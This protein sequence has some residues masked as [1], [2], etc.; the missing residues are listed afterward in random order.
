MLD[1]YAVENACA[2]AWPPLV[3]ARTGDWRLRAA[4]GFTGRANS[5]LVTGSS[6]GGVACALERVRSF[7]ECHG[8]APKLQVVAGDPVEAELRSND[9]VIDDAHCGV[10]GVAVLLGA[11][12]PTARRPALGQVHAT[13]TQGWWSLAAGS[14]APDEA[15]SHVLGTSTGGALGFGVHA[16]G[17]VTTGAVRL[18]VAG[19]LL[20]VSRL[21]VAESARRHGIA[22]GLLA[23][24]ARWGL[25]NGA[26]EA[27]LQVAADNAG[28]LRLYE[29][30]GFAEHHRYRYWSPVAA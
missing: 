5:A 21:E 14:S 24:A 3:E 9:W 10:D 11:L 26:R 22:S 29:R 4:R 28:A 18:A 1:V 6:G 12:A 2:D 30:L 16:A 8:I 19:V 17:G 25:R 13:P 15:R 7:A 27:V 20:H 23:A